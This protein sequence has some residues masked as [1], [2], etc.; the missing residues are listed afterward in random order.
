MIYEHI[1]DYIQHPALVKV[2]SNFYI[3]SFMWMKVC[4]TLDLI[5]SLIDKNIIKQGDTII[6]S[7]SG[8]YAY[9]LALA[10]HKYKL[11]CVIVGSTAISKELHSMISLLG[12]KIHIIKT[13]NIKYSQGDRIAYIKKLLK[14]HKNYYWMQQ[15][16]DR[17]HYLG[18]KI[19]GE[20]IKLLAKNNNINLI[21]GVGT[22]SSSL[23]TLEYLEN[24]NISTKLI[25]I[26][27]FGSIGF[28]AKNVED[29]NKITP[30]GIG[31]DIEFGTLD[32]TKYFKTHYMSFDVIQYFTLK[33][34]MEQAIFA[35]MSSGAT[36]GVGLFESS[37]NSNEIFISISAD[38][39]YRYFKEVYYENSKKIL[40]N[41]YKPIHAKTIDEIRLPWC[42][43]Y[44]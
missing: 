18:Y 41:N 42:Y 34:Y 4:S 3:A 36:Y 11:N 10:C 44:N 13:N 15:Y 26:D 33:L 37:K 20:Q 21:A 35:G 25:A 31:S 7:S 29:P 43:K 12:A 39:G 40:D 6:D 22:G 17:Q 19:L 5:K 8:V 27:L 30:P 1:A 9:S 16:Y 28:D 38:M 23:G 32:R 2:K 14:D 24:F